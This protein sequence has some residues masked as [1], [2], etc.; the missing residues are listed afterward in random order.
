MVINGKS[1]AVKDGYVDI[2]TT[3]LAAGDYKVIAVI[4]EDDMFLA[5]SDSASFTI[6]KVEF[7]AGENPLNVDENKTVESK[8][9]TYSINLP[10]DATGTLN[11][12]IGDKTYTANVVNGK[13]TVK[14]SDMPAGNYNVTI[15][16]SGDD[17]YSPIVKTSKATVKVDPKIV[18][19]D[20]SVDFSGG[21]YYS[22]TVYDED[23]NKA[24]DGTL[25]TFTLNG[26]QVAKVQTKNG[27]AKF[28][29]TQNPV[30]KAKITA[31]ALGK[32]VTKKLTIKHVVKLKTV[33]TV[34][35]SSSKGVTL[36]ATLKINGKYVNKKQIVFKFNG[37]TYKAK[38]KGK[39]VA[40]VTVPATA[41][42]NI[43]GSK[44]T[45]SATY[46]KD[47][48]KKLQDKVSKKAKVIN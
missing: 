5:S 45:Y 1:Y 36:Q 2:D 13:A 27:V 10:E 17:K 7:P 43:K 41:L 4:S 19:K 12:T 44:V 33:S 18:A 8:T 29:V 40:K 34:K 25:V 47:S 16:Y 15:T 11:V 28:K 21:K 20:A 32:T 3:A 26:K 23:G 6:S 46:V 39:G 35:R 22:V 42:K 9:P 38:T 14:V 30:S 31:K 24:K 37:K 48:K